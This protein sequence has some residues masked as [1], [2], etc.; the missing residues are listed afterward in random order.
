M[1]YDAFED[2]VKVKQVYCPEL[3]QAIRQQLSVKHVR[4]IDYSVRRREASFPI[5]TGREFQHAQPAS[6]AHI[7]F[8][9]EE[10]VRMITTLYGSAASQL[11]SQGWAIINAWRPLKHAIKDWPLAVCDKRSF[12]PDLD[13]MASDV[14]YRTWLSENVLIHHNP[15]QKWFFYPGQTTEQLLLFRGPDSHQGLKAA[16]PHAAFRAEREQDTP[17]RESIDCRAI[18]F[19][20][21]VDTLPVEVGTLYGLRDHF[22]S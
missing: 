12:T 9:T 14:V 13:G 16:C 18:V 4:V 2:P 3:A 5:S 1:P 19:Y 11:L 10:A 8:T 20:S 22:P 7:D 15:N 21:M 17:L 6:M